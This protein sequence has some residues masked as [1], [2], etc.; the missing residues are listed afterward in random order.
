[1]PLGPFWI[2]FRRWGFG[3]TSELVRVCWNWLTRRH[4][5]DDGAGGGTLPA[6]DWSLR[7]VFYDYQVQHSQTQSDAFCRDSTRPV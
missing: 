5:V 2:V 3:W 7:R 6:G 4:E 1:M